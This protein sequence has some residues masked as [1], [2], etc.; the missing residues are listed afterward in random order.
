MELRWGKTG[1][2][3]VDRLKQS[4]GIDTFD[5]TRNE[6]QETGG[7][8]DAVTVQ[9]GKYV[10]KDVLL[11]LSKDVANAVNRVG[12][13]ATLQKDFSLQAEVGDDA[14]GQMALKWKKDY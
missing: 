13:E 14:Q 3:V 9:V 4:F 6:S 1:F 12:L 10:A 2:N 11:R 8:S 7:P 5:I